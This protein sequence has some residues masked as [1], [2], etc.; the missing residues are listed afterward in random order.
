MY[1]YIKA[2]RRLNTVVMLTGSLRVDG[3]D[4]RIDDSQGVN[5]VIN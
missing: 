4:G 3:V 1:C 5:Y 2:L